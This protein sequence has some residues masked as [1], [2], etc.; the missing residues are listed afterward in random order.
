MSVRTIGKILLPIVLLG[1]SLAGGLAIGVSLYPNQVFERTA[2]ASMENMQ[3]W[4]KW[5]HLRKV[6]DA[7][8]RDVVRPNQDTIYSSAFV[9]LSDRPYLL[10]IPPIEGYFSFTVYGDNTDVL[11]I[12]SSRTHENREEHRL[13]IAGPSATLNSNKIDRILAPSD[14]VWILA[15]FY[16][17]SDSDYPIANGIQDALKL[18]PY[19]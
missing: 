11:G 12:V 19:K 4:A 2:N 5:L 18:E 14:K 8:Y 9:D 1:A 16:I 3:G 7:E 17:Q 15:R 13:L 6:V 10:T